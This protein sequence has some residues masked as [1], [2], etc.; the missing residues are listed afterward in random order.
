M[1]KNGP[2]KPGGAV[3]YEF[4]LKKQGRTNFLTVILTR[5]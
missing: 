3:F 5:F 2:A 4:F 1:K